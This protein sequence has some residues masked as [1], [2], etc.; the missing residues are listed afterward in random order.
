MHEEQEVTPPTLRS[1]PQPEREGAYL[2]KIIDRLDAWSPEVSMVKPSLLKRVIFVQEH[3]YRE[4]LFALLVME[5]RNLAAMIGATELSFH[6]EHPD[7]MLLDYFRTRL[8]MHGI[9]K[10]ELCFAAPGTYERVCEQ[11]Y[12][13]ASDLLCSPNDEQLQY[14]NEWN[15]TF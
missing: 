13:K 2:Y 14:F 9:V 6:P 11:S 4:R 7:R 8:N 1:V 12:V 5:Q 10:R 15:V 3:S